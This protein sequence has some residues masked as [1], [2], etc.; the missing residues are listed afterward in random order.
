MA[1]FKQYTKKDGTKLWMFTS[2]I[3]VDY[4]TGKQINTTRRGFKTKKEAQQSLNNLLAN[5]KE[6]IKQKSYTFAEMYELWFEVY[7]TTVKETTYLQT[8]SRVKNHVLPVL[9]DIKLDRLDLR[10][11]QKIVNIWAKKFDMY[12]VLLQYAVKVYDY[13]NRL[14]IIDT[15][16]FRKV[17]KPKKLAVSKKR[18]IKFY[19]KTELELF[20]NATLEKNKLMPENCTVGKYYTEFDIAIFRLLAFSGCRIGEICALNWNDIDFGK[21]TVTI[22]KNLSRTNKG[23]DV[24]TTKTDRSNRMI[25]LDD[26]TLSTLKRWKFRQKEL[27]FKNGITKIN[28]IFTNAYGSMCCGS[29]VYKRSNQ[30]ARDANLPN[31]GCHGFRHTHATILFEAGVPAKEVQNRLG[32]KDVTMTLNIYTHVSDEIEKR[33]SEAFANYV[34]F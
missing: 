15:N 30:I 25:T 26:K 12:V 27:L 3:G 10:T 5:P 31:I 24:S 16:P 19:T 17:I 14:E 7:Q 4:V 21:K 34:N 18:K 2:Y 8:D 9:G 29:D 33:T 20:L 22:D 6:T 13:A 23:Y 28:F 11:A 32:H 1:T